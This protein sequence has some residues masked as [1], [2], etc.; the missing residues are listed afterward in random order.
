[1]VIFTK[2]NLN[3]KLIFYEAGAFTGSESMKRNFEIDFKLTLTISCISESCIE[4]KIKLNFYFNTSSW[5]RKKFFE[6]L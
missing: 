5:F 2:E 6:G 4:I 3:G 1:M